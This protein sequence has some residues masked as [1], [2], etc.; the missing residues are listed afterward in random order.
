MDPDQ[1]WLGKQQLQRGLWLGRT[2]WAEGDG[3][4]LPRLS[5]GKEGAI[6]IKPKNHQNCWSWVT[7]TALARARHPQPCLASGE[8]LCFP[9]KRKAAMQQSVRATPENICTSSA[10]RVNH[11]RNEHQS[12]LWLK[13]DVVSTP[14][15]MKNTI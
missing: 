5:L 11:D 13:M 1:P 2:G 10:S 8:L 15:H 4:Q 6:S 3:Q 12:P 14:K 9:D 7:T